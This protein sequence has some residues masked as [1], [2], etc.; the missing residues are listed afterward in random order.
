MAGKPTDLS[1]IPPELADT[2]RLLRDGLRCLQLSG[3]IFLRADFTAPWAYAS[4]A[5]AEIVRMLQPG[6]RRVVLF[7]IITE[8]QCQVVLERGEQ[9]ELQAGDIAIFPHADPHCLGNPDIERPVPI[10]ELLPPPPWTT[11]PVIH[12]GGGGARLSMVCGYLYSDDLPLNPVLASLPPLIRVR[13]SGGPL[14]QWVEASVQY[15][16][17]ASSGRGGGDDPLLQRLPEL[18]FMECLCEFVRHSPTAESGWLAALVDP[19]VGRALACLHRQPELP[20]T[21]K[22]LARRA[23][24]SRSVLDERF[25]ALLGRAPMN[26]LTSWRLQL[27]GRQLRTT[28]ATLA[29]IAEAIGYGSEASLSRAFKRQVGV[30][31][32]QW[33]QPESAAAQ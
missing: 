11:F 31:P 30:S 18:L 6:G 5:T 14:A 25:R 4:P 32:G 20:W 1:E 29:E 33:R 10:R 3:A 16:L 22:E 15:A 24:S 23:A 13:P 2:G 28:N 21:L 17:H 8:G 9:A 27:A 7:H 12:H 19:V 26:Y